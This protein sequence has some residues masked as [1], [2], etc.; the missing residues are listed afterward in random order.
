MAPEIGL[1]TDEHELDDVA[2]EALAVAY[3]EPAPGASPPASPRRGSARA[4]ARAGETPAPSDAHRGCPGGERRPRVGG[5]ARARELQRA[6]GI[7]SE[8]AALKQQNGVLATRLDE[9]GRVLGARLDQQN[10]LLAGLHEALD[11]QSQILRLVG[12]PRVLTAT[13][14][15]QKGVTGTGRV[16]VDA[17]TG[18]AAIML[19]GLAPVGEGKPTSSGR[20]SGKKPPEPA[21]MIAVG[22]TRAAPCG[23]RSSPSERGHGVRRLDRAE[24]RVEL[25][26]R[27]DRPRRRARRVTAT[28][29]AAL[30]G[31]RDGHSGP[32]ALGSASWNDVA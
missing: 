32:P 28:R 14:A 29:R 22:D 1:G 21:G 23:C 30:R 24:R 31:D 25:A 20:S 17:M 6:R 2:L 11:V 10:A 12:G 15:P 9:Q 13:L 27:P 26:D 4:R 19:S 18:D 5:P 3:A 8:L 7:G 16:L